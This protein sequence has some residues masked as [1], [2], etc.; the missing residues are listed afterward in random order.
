MSGNAKRN[1][2]VGTMAVLVCAAVGLNWKYSTQEA[3]QQAEETGTKILGE[4]TLVSGQEG[5]EL[6][7]DTV[8]EGDDYFA[9]ARLTRQQARDSAIELLQKAADEEGAAEEAATEASEGIQALAA[10]TLAE[11]QIENLVTAKGYAD[12]VVFMGEETV[13]VVV[14]DPDGLDAVDVARIK[15]IVVSETGYTPEQIKI[16]EA[17]AAAGSVQTS[18]VQTGGVQTAEQTDD[19]K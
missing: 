16:R 19:A 2:V 18:G 14:S 9:S 17:G 1:L 4:A 12:C 15:D 5:T 11:A 10:Y 3:L 7:E 13:S 8:Y 6:A